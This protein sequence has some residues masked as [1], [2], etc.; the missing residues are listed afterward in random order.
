MNFGFLFNNT[1]P[2]RRNRFWALVVLT[3]LVLA[4]NAFTLN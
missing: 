2:L 4:V 3:L 1:Q